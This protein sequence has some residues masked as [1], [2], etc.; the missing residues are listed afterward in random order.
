[1]ELGAPRLR[2]PHLHNILP[3]EVGELTEEVRRLFEELE[4]RLGGGRRAPAGECIPAIDVLET[5]EAIDVIVDLPGV[6][7][8]SVRL[9]VK[10]GILV[11]AGEK[12]PDHGDR[13]QSNFHLVERGFGRFARAVRLSGAFDAARARA[14]LKAGELR[15][16]IPKIDERR[17]QQIQIPIEEHPHH[18]P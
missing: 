11:I 14:V 7:A 12:A 9:I 13:G 15:L 4:P 16:T 1:M 10:G 3:A 18:E 2:I 8:A 6:S 17:G 5:D